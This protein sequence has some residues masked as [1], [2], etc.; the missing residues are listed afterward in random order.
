MRAFFGTCLENTEITHL[1]LS[2]TLGVKEAMEEVMR[3]F[4]QYELEVGLV[5]EQQNET[6]GVNAI[7]ALEKHVDMLKRKLTEMSERK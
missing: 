7:N 2:V 3:Q 6:V 1:T 5:D 4:E